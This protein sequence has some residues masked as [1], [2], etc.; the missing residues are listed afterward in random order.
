MSE[1]GHGF[2]PRFKLEEAKFFYQKMEFALQKFEDESSMTKFLYFLDAFL[3]ATRNVTF[4]FQREFKHNT[5]LMEWYD[6]K[7]EEWR[8]NKI[9]KLFVE[10]RNISLK[11]HTPETLTL[12]AS[13][14]GFDTSRAIIED[15]ANGKDIQIRIPIYGSAEKTPQNQTQLRSSVVY[16]Y[17]VP[18][19]FDE[20]PD[21]MYLC[22]KYL[23]ELEKFVVE[24][25]NLVK[26]GMN[27]E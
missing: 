18:Q 9:M 13:Q 26:G 25:E 10:M 15:T 14:G 8:N 4:V 6:K 16:F 20:N 12:S 24:A 1:Y 2:E 23:G 3:A 21:V 5:K 22:E 27:H 17:K 7:V 11:E 19:W